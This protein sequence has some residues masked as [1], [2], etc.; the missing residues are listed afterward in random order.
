MAHLLERIHDNRFFAL[1]DKHKPGWN[2]RNRSYES[3]HDYS[4]VYSI[5]ITRSAPETHTITL[6]VT[7]WKRTII[8]HSN[9]IQIELR[10]QQEGTSINTAFSVNSEKKKAILVRDNL[11]GSIE[12]ISLDQYGEKPHWEI[13][14]D[15]FENWNCEL[16]YRHGRR[17]Y[18]PT[19]EDLQYLLSHAINFSRNL[20]SFNKY[21]QKLI[22]GSWQSRDVQLYLSNNS[23]FEITGESLSNSPFKDW[24]SGTEWHYGSGCVFVRIGLHTEFRL[25][26]VNISENQLHFIGRGGN[27]GYLFERLS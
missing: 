17:F 6:D 12:D 9:G 21:A 24:T 13:T 3:T 20:K 2:R 19:L 1:M 4:R 22:A 27:I 25:Q 5:H 11:L 7:M 8:E 10:C 23:K 14:D 16:D 18:P 15:E 26:L